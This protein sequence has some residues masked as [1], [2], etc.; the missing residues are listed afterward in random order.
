VS[1]PRVAAVLMFL[2]GAAP[3]KI[4][5]GQEAAPRSRV[6]DSV[7]PTSASNSDRI[8]DSLRGRGLP[9]IES[10]PGTSDSVLVTFVWHGD[11]STRNVVVVTPLTLL[12]FD[13]SV[14]TRLGQTVLWY[15]SFVLPTDARFTYRF[16]PNDNLIPF[17]R[18][19]NLPARLATLRRDPGNP[20]VFDYGAFGQLSVL[21][22]PRAPS[23]TL[24]HPSTSGPRGA[25]AQFTIHSRL[26]DQDR[27]IWVYTPS[28]KTSRLGRQVPVVVFADGESYQ[29]LIPTPTI[30]DNLI[31]NRD[32]P[33]VLAVFVANPGATRDGDLSCN[34]VWSA[35]VATEVVPWIDAHYQTTHAAR[36]RIVAGYSLGGLAAACTALRYPNVFGGVIAQSGSFFRAPAGEEPEW[37]ARHLARDPRR[38][39]QFALTIGR[40]ETAAIPSRDPSMLTANRHLRD[41]LVA[42]GYDVD[43][44]ELSSGHE[45]VAWRAVLGSQLKKMLMPLELGH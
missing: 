12:D 4:A 14:L 26:L 31:N 15:R 44:Q 33:P 30:L 40:Y 42:K 37:V 45:H 10:L 29:S 5:I 11:S 27:T 22:L 23:D 1:V 9:L 8:W 2:L 38:P 39:I 18:D 16:A 17:E 25:V 35:F 28:G 6:I 41:I 36:K 7:G 21:D 32:V 3:S 24:I 20:K 34:P 43:Y 19:T 13:A